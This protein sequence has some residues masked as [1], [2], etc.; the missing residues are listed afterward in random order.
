MSSPN[1]KRKLFREFTIGFDQR[2]RE[3][4]EDDSDIQVFTSH[5]QQNARNIEIRDRVIRQL[6]FEYASTHGV[7][8]LTKDKRRSFSRE[9][10]HPRSTERWMECAK[11]ARSAG[12]RMT[13]RGCLG[14]ST[15][16]IT[17]C[18]TQREGRRRSTMPKCYAG[19]T[20]FLR[21][22]PSSLSHRI[23]P[24]WHQVVAL[25]HFDIWMILLPEC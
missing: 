22:H 16:R 10:A 4:R 6:F 8:I 5:R 24:V 17:S 11:S 21:E 20:T 9:R 25:I 2:R 18:R 23:V 19:P 14:P 1:R 3:G 7:D 12:A 13:R 15:K